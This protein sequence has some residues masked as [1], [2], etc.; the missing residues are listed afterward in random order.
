MSLPQ[1]LLWQ[2]LQK[3]PDGY[4]FRREFPQAPLTVDFTCL[5]AR[6]VIEVDGMA[7]DMGDQPQRDQ[8]RD[9][10][11]ADRG[12]RTLRLPAKDLLRDMESCVI[13]IVT[14]C[15]EAG[16]PPPSLRDGPP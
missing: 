2:Q 10:M 14:A 16:P 11:M 1:V 6:L 8:V 5:S 9:R 15:R 7:H 3:R 12:F 13:A 4:K